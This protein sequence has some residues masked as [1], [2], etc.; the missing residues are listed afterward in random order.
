[1]LYPFLWLAPGWDFFSSVHRIPSSIFYGAASVI[2]DLCFIYFHHRKF[3]FLPQLWQITWL[4]ILDGQLYLFKTW[5]ALFWSSFTW[6]ICVIVMALLYIWL[7]SASF[8]LC[9]YC[10]TYVR[11]VLCRPC[12]FGVLNDSCT[13][14]VI[15][16]SNFWKIFFYNSFE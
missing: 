11:E 14:T 10:C 12:L 4:S 1:M 3:F 15:S 2:T 9:I 7:D 6:G 5:N 13:W 16:F 8:I